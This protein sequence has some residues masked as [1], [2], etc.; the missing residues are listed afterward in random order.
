MLAVE[1]NQD[2]TKEQSLL[3]HTIAAE[4]KMETSE[5]AH[6]GHLETSITGEQTLTDLVTI[7][8]E[9][10]PS[11]IPL[12]KAEKMGPI[13]GQDMAPSGPPLGI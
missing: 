11:G 3:E 5:M 13:P 8:L 6:Q 1:V 12:V 7:H 2:P 4:M 9:Q 10:I